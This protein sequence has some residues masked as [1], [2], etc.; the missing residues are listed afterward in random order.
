MTIKNAFIMIALIVASFASAQSFKFAKDDHKF[1]VK[2]IEN[3]TPTVEFILLETDEEHDAARKE[4]IGHG[5]NKVS[6][7]TR[8]NET[9][10]TCKIYIKDPLWKYEPELIGHEVA[11]CIWGRFHK[12]SKGLRKN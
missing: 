6:A 4:F 10:G 9:E 11:H 2:E 1:L 7:F 3:L 12:G 8:W 5:W